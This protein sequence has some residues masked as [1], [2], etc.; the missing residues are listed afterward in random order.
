MLNDIKPKVADGVEDIFYN[1]ST[2]K[3][4]VFSECNGHLLFFAVA[5]G[6][7]FLLN[8]SMAFSNGMN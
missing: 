7:Y 1:K 6:F 8:Q 4:R 3:C 5:L 2:L